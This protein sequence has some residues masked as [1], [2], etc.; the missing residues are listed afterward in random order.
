MFHSYCFPIRV[1]VS[2][3]LRRKLRQFRDRRCEKGVTS[4]SIFFVVKT[5][6]NRS[7]RGGKKKRVLRSTSYRDVTPF[8]HLFEKKIVEASDGVFRQ[9]NRVSGERKSRL[10]G[11]IPTKF[12]SDIR[13]G[14]RLPLR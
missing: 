3:V 10:D 11:N 9:P 1:F 14:A 4:Q 2:E 12:V 8:S 6:L 5:C 7:E 13:S